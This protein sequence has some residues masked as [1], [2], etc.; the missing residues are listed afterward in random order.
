VSIFPV[1]FDWSVGTV[2]K[3]LGNILIL[4][5]VFSVNTSECEITNW[6]VSLRYYSTQKVIPP[7]N[8]NPRNKPV[9]PPWHLLRCITTKNNA[10]TP[11][12][13]VTAS[14]RVVKISLPFSEIVGS[15]LYSQVSVIWPQLGPNKPRPNPHIVLPERTI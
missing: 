15:F 7:G 5:F 9:I 13:F 1:D 11:R 6:C 4:C 12:R 10:L 8:V 3:C 2:A 14:R